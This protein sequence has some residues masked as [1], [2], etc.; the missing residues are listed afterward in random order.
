MDRASSWG[1]WGRKLFQTLFL[2][3]LATFLGS[4]LLGSILGVGEGIVY[5]MLYCA[6][7]GLLG[8]LGHAAFL[9]QYR[10]PAQ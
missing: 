2:W 9:W 4:A 7:V 1:E 6:P 10:P 8:F 5:F 3:S